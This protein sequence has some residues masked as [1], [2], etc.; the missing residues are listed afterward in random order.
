MSLMVMCLMAMSLIIGFVRAKN[1]L[2]VTVESIWLNPKPLWVCCNLWNWLV[3]VTIKALLFNL[4]L[5]FLKVHDFLEFT[6]LRWWL[7]HIQHRIVSYVWSCWIMTIMDQSS[8]SILRR[9]L[10]HELVCSNLLRVRF[11][12]SFEVLTLVIIL[13]DWLAMFYVWGWSDLSNWSCWSSDHVGGKWDI[14]MRHTIL[15]T[16]KLRINYYIR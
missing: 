4:R 3:L 1:R 11:G 10:H 5:S 16:L 8:A 6:V 13:V 12:L 7:R 2:S 14:F 15:L 9:I